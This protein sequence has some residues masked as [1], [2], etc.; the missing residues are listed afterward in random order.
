MGVVTPAMACHE[1][2]LGD[3]AGT[4]AIQKKNDCAFELK[5]LPTNHKPS[6][7]N[8]ASCLALK[9]GSFECGSFMGIGHRVKYQSSDTQQGLFSQKPG[10]FLKQ[11]MKVEKTK[12]YRLF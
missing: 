12:L 2:K 1:I 10:L 5:T 4:Y 6:A 11:P 8:A 7:E 3:Q 9:A